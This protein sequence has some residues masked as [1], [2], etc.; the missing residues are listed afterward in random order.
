[1]NS[2]KEGSAREVYLEFLTVGDS[3]KVT[4]IDSETG[5]EVSIVGPVRAPRSDLERVAVD[6]LHYVLERQ[7]SDTINTDEERPVNE[8]GK[9]WVA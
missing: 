2:G 8:G 4:A 1:L 6:K 3:I 7:S 5:T 9:G